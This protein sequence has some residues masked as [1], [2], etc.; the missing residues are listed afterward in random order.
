MILYPQNTVFTERFYFIQLVYVAVC[1]S[2][3][4]IASL[5]FFDD[6]ALLQGTFSFQWV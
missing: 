5:I 1:L 6:T 2:T 3:Q 4:V